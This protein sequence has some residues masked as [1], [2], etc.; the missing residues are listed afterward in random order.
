MSLIKMCFP[1]E[2][3]LKYSFTWRWRWRAWG[4]CRRWPRC[5]WSSWGRRAACA[6]PAWSAPALSPSTTWTSSTLR[7]RRQT[8]RWSHTHWHTHTEEEWYEQYFSNDL[9]FLRSKS[10]RSLKMKCLEWLY[11]VFTCCHFFVIIS[12]IKFLFYFIEIV[13]WCV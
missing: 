2:I 4:A 1:S 11:E 6:E 13:F 10:R 12:S 9:Y 8:D 3:K 7:D 5:P